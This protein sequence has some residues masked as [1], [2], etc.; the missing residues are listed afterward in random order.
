MDGSLARYFFFH[1]IL[2]A[3]GMPANQLF[4]FFDTEVSFKTAMDGS[5]ARYYCFQKIVFRHLDFAVK[6]FDP[7]IFSDT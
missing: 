3:L 4:L 1:I 2:L 7:Q 6:L 5:L